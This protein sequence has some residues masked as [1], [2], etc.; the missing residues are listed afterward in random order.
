MSKTVA[1]AVAG[2]VLSVATTASAE[3]KS[4]A[5]VKGSINPKANVIA[6]GSLAA[7][8]STKAFTSAIQM[9]LSEEAD[10]KRAFDLIKDGCNIDVPTA[11]AD[12][13]LVMKDGDNPLVVFG[14]DGLDEPRVRTCLESIALKETGKAVKLTAKKA[15]K[16][17]IYSVPGEREKLYFAW[18]AK[19]VVAFTEDPTNKGK[20]AA[21][22][23]KRPAKGDLGKLVAKVNTD[24]ALWAA[25]AIK[26]KEDGMTIL[27]GYGGVELAGGKWKGA[28][29][30]LMGSAADVQKAV[31]M[32]SAGLGEIKKQAKGTPAAPLIDSIQI[33]GNGVELDVSGSL[34]DTDITKL[35]ADLEH[36]F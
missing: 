36:I 30:V 33:S 22:L 6:G 23:G 29:H 14:L 2:L 13:T 16:V 24:A 7:A 18:L 12:F 20:L 35:I 27:G 34:V 15:G 1:V 8:R 10:A 28:A 25:V 11:I 26:E 3:S 21:A 19:D 9:L 17:T 31:G 4:W 5:A 32:G